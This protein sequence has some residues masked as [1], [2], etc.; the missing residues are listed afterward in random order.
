MVSQNIITDVLGL[1]D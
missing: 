1:T